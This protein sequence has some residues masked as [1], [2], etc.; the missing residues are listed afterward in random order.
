MLKVSSGATDSSVEASV[1][2]V[3]RCGGIQVRTVPALQSYRCEAGTVGA[4][5]V[6]QIIGKA[7]AGASLA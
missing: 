2:E 4:A 5:Q 7:D 1:M 3:E 6:P